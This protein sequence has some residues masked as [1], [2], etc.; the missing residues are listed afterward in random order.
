MIVDLVDI[1]HGHGPL[2][3]KRARLAR[4]G[5]MLLSFIAGTMLGAV[6]YTTFGFYSLMVPILTVTA[7]ALRIRPHPVVAA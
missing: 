6:G 2:E 1:A 4:L 3:I 7:L 5:P